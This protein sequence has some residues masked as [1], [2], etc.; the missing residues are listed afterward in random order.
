[1]ASIP[2]HF[3]KATVA[4]GTPNSP[5]TIWIGSGFLYGQMLHS[6]P[7]E[8]IQFRLFLVTNKHVVENQKN[9][10]LRFENSAGGAIELTVQLQNNGNL[11]WTGHSDPE[12]DVAVLP[13]DGNILAKL[14]GP[15][16]FFKDTDNSL[17][18]ANPIA[19]NLCEGDPIF[20]LGFPLGLVDN[21]EN[22]PV[23]RGGTLA[24][25]KD[26]KAKRTKYFL[27]DCQTFPGNSGGP[28]L[29]K[30]EMFALAGTTPIPT[31]YLIGI[32]KGYIPYR[33]VAI[34]LQTRR[35][36]IVFEENSGLSIVFPV[37]CIDQTIQIAINAGQTSQAHPKAVTDN[38]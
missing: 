2:N 19:D 31:C 35:E 13:I 7:Q 37:D 16:F 8:Q 1:M 25:L 3:F 30:P 33:D 15:L 20:I 26:C 11:I 17:S 10:N 4:I 12:V 5:T 28:V 34:S 14:I 29:N 24:R 22:L 23:I 27:V 18:L 21:V 6:N 36:K 32:V 9:V 38:N